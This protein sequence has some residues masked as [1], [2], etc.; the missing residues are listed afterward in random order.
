MERKWVWLFPL[1][2]LAENALA[3]GLQTHLYF[4]G[5]LASAV[6]LSSPLLLRAI[7]RFPQRVL[8]GACL[9]DLALVARSDHDNPLASTHHWPVATNWLH[10]AETDE[11]RALAIGF[12]SHLLVDVIAHHQFV[13]WHEAHWYHIP[14]LTH[15]LSELA[16]DAWVE[17]TFQTPRP[18]EIL[19]PQIEAITPCLVRH[20]EIRPAEARRSL[21]T[22]ARGDAYLRATT[23]PQLT[24]R[25]ARLLDAGHEQRLS[26]FAEATPN[27]QRYLDALMC[28]LQPRWHP[29]SPQPDAG[30]QP[31]LPA[32]LLHQ[33]S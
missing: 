15:A 2:F 30:W 19:L 13:P 17:Q 25:M 12:A 29:D 33:P 11:E 23:V 24:L 31:H 16:M 21:K 10:T 9:P 18:A 20:F 32:C 22:L 3:W 14:V 28:G 4:A 7:R 26:F 5:L 27:F 6:P 8:A 1:F